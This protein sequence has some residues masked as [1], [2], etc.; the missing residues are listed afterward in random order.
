M[1]ELTP[2]RAM[3]A[4]RLYAWLRNREEDCQIMATV[5]KRDS[6]EYKHNWRIISS[7]QYKSAALERYMNVTEENRYSSTR[8]IRSSM[9]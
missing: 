5:F 1:K 9:V 4:F 3:R 7:L 6:V 2:D 8:P